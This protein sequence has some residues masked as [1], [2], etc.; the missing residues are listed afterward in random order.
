MLAM[1]SL[2]WRAR[3]RPLRRASSLSVRLHA[4]AEGPEAAAQGNMSDS[5]AAFDDLF[6]SMMPVAP[7]KKKEEEEEPWFRGDPISV[8]FKNVF[9]TPAVRNAG[10]DGR[11][12]TKPVLESVSWRLE[13]NERVGLIGPNGCGK[14]TQLL[15]I[16][17]IIEPTTG[18]VKNRPDNMRMAFMQQEAFFEECRSV[19]DEL[20]TAFADRPLE[21]ID[22][23]IEECAVDPD[24]MDELQELLDERA[25][26]E[27]HLASIEKLIPELGL[28]SRRN[29]LMDDLSGGWQMRVALGKIILGDPQLILLD[30]PTNHI[31]LATVEF[32]ESFLR[33]RDVAMVI[34]SHDRYFLNQVCTKIVE[35][36]EGVT[37]TYNGNYVRYLKSRDEALAREWRTYQKFRDRVEQMEKQIRKLQER[38][39]TQQAAQKRDELQAIL[40]KPVPKPVVNELRDFRFPFDGGEDDAERDVATEVD[41]AFWSDETEG[42]S[43]KDVIPFLDVRDLH[44]AY[45]DEKVLEGISFQ[46]GP[47]EKVAVVGSNGCG[48]T[49]MIRAVADDL[50]EDEATVRGSIYH[51]DRG[52]A[53]FPQRLA[54]ALNHMTDSVK[55]ALYLSCEVE[56]IDKAGGLPAVLSR[57]RLDGVTAEQ[58]VNTLSGGEKAR[59]A[60]ASFLLRPCAMLVLD[61]P[62]NHLDIPTRELL[63]DALK[64]Y[65]GAALVVSH[66]RFFL[67]E[68]ATR[69]VEIAE[70]QLINHESWDAYAAAAPPQWHAAESAEVDFIEQDAVAATIWANKKLSR[71]K[72]R[73]SNVGM[74]RLSSRTDEFIAQ[75]PAPRRPSHK[76][77]TVIARLIDGGVDRSLLGPHARTLPGDDDEDSGEYAV[78]DLG[79]SDD[80][81]R[82]ETK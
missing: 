34:V 55:N 12:S 29:M 25:L 73:Y 32:M 7:L 21:A 68:F 51:T 48:K 56:D 38:F 24:A 54:E 33:S 23:D 81:S 58:P 15:M 65:E 3:R 62:T 66:D 28:T 41:D 60:F 74:R 4:V 53:Y 42:T 75:M 77:D 10:P 36:R 57:L 64:E 80:S 76:E 14:S 61:E 13:G 40:D 19:Y 39:I 45:G 79:G 43:Q 44:V 27:E 52:I 71:V 6:G 46:V 30:E 47:G 8:E 9:W 78:K 17:G 72:K 67:R 50:D 31:D 69:V 49:T 22:A 16:Q 35:T 18:Q 2:L 20:M 59:V 11:S 37:R 82:E 26:V 1:G 70:G 5:I 63:E